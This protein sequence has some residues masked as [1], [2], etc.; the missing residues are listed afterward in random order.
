MTDSTR[1]RKTTLVIGGRGET[2][3]RVVDRLRVD[4]LWASRSTRR[5]RPRGTPHA[6]AR[7]PSR[8]A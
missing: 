2:W 8:A 3:R 7:T 4:G 1:D 5:A 6:L